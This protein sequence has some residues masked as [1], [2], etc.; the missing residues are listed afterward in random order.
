MSPKDNQDSSLSQNQNIISESN[1]ANPR[2]G[3]RIG[4]ENSAMNAGN[5]NIVPV[6]SSGLIQ[7]QEANQASSMEKKIV[8]KQQS[9]EIEQQ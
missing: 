6:N 7:E 9:N 1:I 8:D 3:E 5:Q 4:D 2:S